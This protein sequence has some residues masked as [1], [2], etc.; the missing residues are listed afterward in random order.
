MKRLVDHNQPAASPGSWLAQGTKFG[1]RAWRAMA[2]GRLAQTGVPWLRARGF[3]L[4]ISLQAYAF[5]RYRRAR[6][7]LTGCRSFTGLRWAWRPGLV[8]IVLPVYNGASFV[9][10]ALDSILEQ[11]YP[12]WE[13]IAVDDGSTDE[14]GAILDE[15]CQKDAR[16]KA[17][18]QEN[19]KLPAALST[20][21]RLAQGEFL[22]WTSCDNLLYPDFLER[23]VD[24]LRR[25]PDWDMVYAN[26][27][28]IDETG[29]PLRD[30]DWYRSYQIPLDSE[31]IQLPKDPSELNTR[32]DNY[33]GAAFLYRYRVAGL[34]GDYSQN[35]YTV[36]DYDY[37]MRV[38]ALLHLRHAGFAAPIY[39]FR[40]HS[41]SLTSRAKELAIAENQVN[42]VIYDGFRR[43]FCLSPLLWQVESQAGPAAQALAGLLRQRV[44]G[45]GQVILGKD[46]FA[47]SSLPRF[48]SPVVYVRVVERLTRQ[49]LPPS[50]LPASA[51][52]VLVV[53]QDAGEAADRDLAGWDLCT[54]LT[55]RQPIARLPGACRAWLAAP[56]AEL[57]FAAI[58]TWA[59]S[60]HLAA[61]E[62]EMAQPPVPTLKATV[63]IC[64]YKRIERLEAAVRSAARQEFPPDAYE[65]IIVNNDP[66]ARDLPL[67]ADRLRAAYF[68]GRPERLRLVN[69]PQPG[70]SHARNAGI[71][72]ARGEI[73]CFLD[74]DAR[75][76]PGWLALVWRA[77]ADH[78]Q[79]GVV[80]G[81][82]T[83]QKPAPAPRWLRPGWEIYWSHF[84]P[85][86]AQFTLVNHWRLFP[87]GA[88]WCARRKALFE[89]GGFRTYGFGRQG[90]KIRDGEE[91]ALASLIAQLGYEIGVEPRAEVLHDVEAE[92]FTLGFV[93]RKIFTGRRQW[94]QSQLELQL[95]DELGIRMAIR[96]LRASIWPPSL[97]SLL[98][99][100]YTLLA[101]LLVLAW[102]T[103][104]LLRR[105][106]KPV[107][108]K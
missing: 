108:C 8:S 9:Q 89:V 69:C 86:Y 30:S 16:I 91:V 85:D 107:A 39:A 93:A 42:L 97:I 52:K 65:V 14:S 43:D 90:R 71:S 81:K 1:Q 50:D 70:L 5:D 104:D 75:A 55:D 64:S 58:D 38:N 29:T 77:F 44:A 3:P 79:A 10:D 17:I 67:L 49:H 95:P 15:Y 98:K 11:S 66:D 41:Q 88:N 72:E 7:K 36:E 6:L 33:L 47:P 21:F 94:Y 100:P 62:R 83:L 54:H 105:F 78:P 23:L 32:P 68:P 25:H 20:G 106:R 59:R 74:D 27:D 102:A 87:Y 51:L 80:G 31:H 28:I 56:G 2:R 35:F 26:L 45:S 37:W 99:G 24:C 60:A 19:Q 92:R 4:P 73:V 96:R 101:E 46:R 22:T 61:F 53:C 34:L 12:E 40:F 84:A 76:T 63:V 103:A 82:I 18:H 13:L 48:W 57:L